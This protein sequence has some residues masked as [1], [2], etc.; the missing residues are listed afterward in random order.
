MNPTTEILAIKYIM[1][2]DFESLKQLDDEEIKKCDNVGRSAIHAA[3]YKG[4]VEILNYL[5]QQRNFDK[6]QTDNEGKNPVH[7][8]CGMEWT[9]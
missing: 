1:E 9:N 8:C 7:Y 3:C 2:N 6:D 4:N 5:L